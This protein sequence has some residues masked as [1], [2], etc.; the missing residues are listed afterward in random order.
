MEESPT[1]L[2]KYW[3]QENPSNAFVSLAFSNEC[4]SDDHIVFQLLLAMFA[5]A[6]A[7]SLQFSGISIPAYVVSILSTPGTKIN[8]K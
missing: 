3:W 2:Q 7:L 6:E 5:E 1:A 8:F 4:R